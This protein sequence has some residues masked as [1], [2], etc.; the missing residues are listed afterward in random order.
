[1][2]NQPNRIEAFVAAVR[3]RLNRHRLWTVL[4]WTVAAAAGVLVIVG[5][6]YTIPGYAVPR[7]L[8]GWTVAVAAVIG[9]AA[10]AIARRSQDQAAAFADRFFGLK[11]AVA[12]Y[13]HFSRAERRDGYYALQAVQTTD[14]VAELDAG[15]VRYRPPRRGLFLAFGLVAIAVPLGLR[16]PSD[17]V[18]QQQRL[19]EVTQRETESINQELEEMVEQLR[20]E[21]PDPLEKEL[22]VPDK[23]RKWVDELAVTKDQKEALRQYARLERK[24]N[25][26]RLAT[27]R[28]RDEQL[29]N[30]AAAELANSPETKPLAKPLEEK[31][32]DRAAQ[33]LHKLDPKSNKPLSQQR[34][35]LAR[36][37]AASQRMASAA[38]SQSGGGNGSDGSDL[39]QSME[40]LSDAV[41]N[42]DDALEEAERQESQLGECTSEQMSECQSCQKQASDKLC[43]MCDGLKK[44]STMRRVEKKISML[45][46]KCSNCQS[47]LCNACMACMSPKAGGKKAGWASAESHR[48][49]IDELVDNGQTTQLKGIKGRGPSLTTVESADD[50]SGVSTRQSTARVRDYQK[51]FESFVQREDVPEQVKQGV[52]RYFEIIHEGDEE[53]VAP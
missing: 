28:R 34:R 39:A 25:E 47:G 30:R 49:N 5:L 35:E 7:S 23:L 33:Q 43:K 18:L 51:Q 26:A 46:K 37:K 27:Q 2:T 20:E 48:I 1:M 3:S 22:L 17:A 45:C 50:G 36:L 24:L 15:S 12:S 42:L 13:L 44:L 29:W 10:W 4:I 40:D 21:T 8:I 19:E 52:K 14:Q 38:S 16:G 41:N 32:Y 6:W 11:N 9:V 31:N 53:T